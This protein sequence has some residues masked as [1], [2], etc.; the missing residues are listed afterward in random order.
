LDE[1]DL[2]AGF[3]RYFGDNSPTL[4]VQAENARGNKALLEEMNLYASNHPGQRAQAA[5]LIFFMN[6]GNA[7]GGVLTQFLGFGVIKTAHRVTQ[8]HKGRSFTNYAFDC[9]LFR[10]EEDARGREALGFEWIDARR[11]AGLTDAEAN[12]AA[13]RSWRRWL[14]EGAASLD[15]PSVH[16]VVLRGDVES[17]DDQVPLRDTNLGKVLEMVYRRYDRNYKHGFQ[18]LAALVTKLVV[19]GEDLAYQEGWVTPEGPDGGVDFVQR[20]D[21][22]RGFSSTRLVV[23]GQ[24]KCKKPWPRA[25]NGINAEDLARVVARLRRG[26]IGAYVT[27]SFFTE[28]AQREMV[29]DDYPIILIPGKRVAL[30]VDVMRDTL[31]FPTVDKLLDWVDGAYQRMLSASMSRPSDIT[32]AAPTAM[33]PLPPR[34]E[35]E[36]RTN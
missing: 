30:A 12:A 31:G 7:A 23:L 24:A 8:L 20:L 27:T 3:I 5:P 35:T 26:W 13:P 4:R 22:G 21:L 17:Y 28:V 15:G 10:G 6:L 18:A 34:A 11:N 9:L 29:A 32:R 16:R 14:A 2:D 36:G 1:V 25:T 33:D 19:G